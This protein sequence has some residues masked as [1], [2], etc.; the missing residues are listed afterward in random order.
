VILEFRDEGRG[1]PEQ[2]ELVTE[3]IDAVT[4]SRGGIGTEFGTDNIES[5]GGAM[6]GVTI[7]D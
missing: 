2:G 5:G 4:R 3:P 6:E 1:R 7:G